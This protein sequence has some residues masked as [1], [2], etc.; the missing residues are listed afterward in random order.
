V[1]V[2][3][4]MDQFFF[5]QKAFIVDGGKVLLVRKSASDPNQPGK[6]EV[7]GG[8]MDFGEEVDDHIK[9]EVKEE[10]G[11]N[12]A[13]GTPFFV[14]QW[15]IERTD[16]AGQPY[17]MQVVA[18]ARRCAAL[19]SALSADNQVP[20]DHLGEMKWVPIDELSNYDFIPNMLP[21]VDAFLQLLNEKP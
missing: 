12:I 13:P 5:A 10:V 16:A 21:V 15:L 4:E 11:V 19:S 3:A 18:V 7:P 9:R 8:R 1:R 6:W 14:W 2:E 20:E 17:R